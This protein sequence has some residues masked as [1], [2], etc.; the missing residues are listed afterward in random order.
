M[1]NHSHLPIQ[2]NNTT[3]HF[4]NLIP[5][6]VKSRQIE[7]LQRN[8]SAAAV[9]AGAARTRRHQR[10]RP[11]HYTRNT[12]RLLRSRRNGLNSDAAFGF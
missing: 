9:R 2:S 10:G 4:S 11:V 3:K 7:S 1:K 8:G 5:K 6:S 12:V